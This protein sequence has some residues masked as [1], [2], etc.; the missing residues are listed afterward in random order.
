V[1]VVPATL[2][3]SLIVTVELAGAKPLKVAVTSGTVAVTVTDSE[4]L[5]VLLGGIR[6]GGEQ[7]TALTVSAP[8]SRRV[9]IVKSNIIRLNMRG[10]LF[11]YNYDQ[12]N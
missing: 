11:N 5:Q 8:A 10:F 1:I 4:T 6:D 3:P 9:K 2:G 12:E 7:L